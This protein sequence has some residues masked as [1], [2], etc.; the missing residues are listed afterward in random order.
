MKSNKKRR[1]LHT[2]D[3]CCTD[4]EQGCQQLSISSLLE[5][6]LYTLLCGWSR[7]GQPHAFYTPRT[8]TKADP[9]PSVP[10]SDGTAWSYVGHSLQGCS[11]TT[12]GQ[13]GCRAWPYAAGHDWDYW[14]HL[15]VLV[16]P[17]LA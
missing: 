3:R 17:G 4:R 2:K 6:P 11:P 12:A 1:M 14:M 15:A 13:A 8:G 16:W 7:Q 9:T 10:L 5:N